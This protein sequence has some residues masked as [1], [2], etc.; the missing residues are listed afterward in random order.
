MITFFV[1]AIQIQLW[2]LLNFAT[3]ALVSLS[4][5]RQVFQCFYCSNYVTVDGSG[6]L[7]TMNYKGDAT[8][9]ILEE[10]LWYKAGMAIQKGNP[11]CSSCLVEYPNWAVKQSNK[12][13]SAFYKRPQQICACCT[14]TVTDVSM[15]AAV[16]AAPAVASSS[17]EVLPPPPPPP[18]PPQP[19]NF[20]AA[21]QT[22]RHMQT[23]VAA[24]E[25]R[26]ED[27]DEAMKT[28]QLTMAAMVNAHERNMND[29]NDY[30]AVLELRM[31][32]MEQAMLDLQLLNHEK[33][34]AQERN[35]CN[36]IKVQ[37]PQNEDAF[38]KLTDV[39]LVDLCKYNIADDANDDDIRLPN[40]M[41]R[42]LYTEDI[43][44]T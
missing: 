36:Y 22:V 34:D 4:N 42:L 27:S 28:M 18:P 17:H 37:E 26:I 16:A 31:E 41:G 44:Y 33:T 40:D 2:L 38:I 24:L 5:R 12:A 6:C 3:M 21:M 25:A 30:V 14:V 20:E 39:P 29:K 9:C 13:A 23:K 19:L 32:A 35:E 8:E 10:T 7:R 43:R 1:L 11:C 15:V